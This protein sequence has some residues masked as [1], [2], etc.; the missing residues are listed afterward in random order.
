M[1]DKNE[2]N[3]NKK[4]FA[5]V[6]LKKIKKSN[7]SQSVVNISIEEVGE[8]LAGNCGET[9]LFIG[10]LMHERRLP[11]NTIIINTI[12]CIYAVE[13][14][15]A[16]LFAWLKTQENIYLANHE[17]KLMKYWAKP[18]ISF[19]HPAFHPHDKII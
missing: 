6:P 18:C 17:D 1:T 14:T 19:R 7:Q 2:K 13:I 16:D 15:P 3:G 4:G 9:A 8:K 10:R 12:D 5:D 11:M